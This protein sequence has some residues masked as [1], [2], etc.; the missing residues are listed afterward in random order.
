MLQ[1]IAG[2][3]EIPLEGLMSMDEIYPI[4]SDWYLNGYPKGAKAKIPGFDE[5]MS[6]SLGQLTMVTGIPGHG[7]DEFVNLI[8]ANL[9]R[10]ED[11]SWGL[12]EFEETPPQTVSKLIEK[13]TGKSFDFRVNEDHRINVSEFEYGIGMVDKYFKFI[14]TQEVETDIDGVLRMAEQMVKRYGIKGFRLNPWNWVESS[15]PA[16]MSETEFISNCLSKIILFSKRF[17]VHFILIA[18]TTKISKGLDGKYLV[19]TL[20][21]INGSANFFNKT[22]NGFVVYRHYDTNNVDVIIQKVK[23]SWL[24]TLGTCNFSY[25]TYTRQYLP[26]ETCVG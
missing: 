2:A 16:Y 10:F 18:H 22:H 5:L 11:W 25:D 20:Y 15:R 23:Q 9:A 12:C 24:G 17:Q 3:K 1:I 8:M 7:K 4:I 26:I 14:N 6:F 19:P 21:S 13:F